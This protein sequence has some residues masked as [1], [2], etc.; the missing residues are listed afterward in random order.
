MSTPTPTSPKTW[1]E[2]LKPYRTEL[3]AGGIVIVAHIVIV[4]M[5]WEY[6][7]EHYGKP[8]GFLILISIPLTVFC[9]FLLRYLLRK[10]VLDPFTRNLTTTVATAVDDVLHKYEETVLRKPVDD[11]RDKFE[12]MQQKYNWINFKAARSINEFSAKEMNKVKIGLMKGVNDCV[13]AIHR[14]ETYLKLEPEDE[15]NYFEDN[16]KA[17]ER[18]RIHHTNPGDNHDHN[19]HRI[20]IISLE[21]LNDE[22]LRS[23]I[24]L[25]I[26]AH[27]NANMDIKVVLKENLIEVP[28]FEFAIYDNEIALKLIV[29]QHGQSYGEGTVY[30]NEA[31]IKDVYKERYKEIEAQSLKAEDFWKKYMV[32]AS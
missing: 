5:L 14:I 23:Q 3:I 28:A 17:L 8:L 15:T 20:F 25:K 1:R 9:L 21:A 31:V 10:F 27:C 16:K 32:K 26:D 6:L 30:F 22:T 12:R 24:Q 19:I 7:A 29:N 13:Y 4:S 2:I 18:I 11:I